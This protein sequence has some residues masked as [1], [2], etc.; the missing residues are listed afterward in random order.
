MSKLRYT[1]FLWLFNNVILLQAFFID[2]SRRFLIFKL[3]LTNS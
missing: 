1:L 3:F 2:V